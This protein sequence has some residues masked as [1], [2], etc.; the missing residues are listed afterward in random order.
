MTFYLSPGERAM[1][2]AGENCIMVRIYPYRMALYVEHMTVHIESGGIDCQIEPCTPD[3][4]L[5]RTG[6]HTVL[7][8]HRI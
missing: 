1:Y 6:D 7:S 2:L 4:P 8:I 5:Y 3:Q